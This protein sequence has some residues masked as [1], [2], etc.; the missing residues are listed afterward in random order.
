M[1]PDL[2]AQAADLYRA[3]R[4]REAREEDL[5]REARTEA[6]RD[7]NQERRRARPEGTA[8]QRGGAGAVP[9]AV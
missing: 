1:H 9:R 5:L 4:E 6:R 7:S 3:D 2:A 8:E